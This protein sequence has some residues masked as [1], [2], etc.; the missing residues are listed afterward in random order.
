MTQPVVHVALCTTGTNSTDYRDFVAHEAGWR[1]ARS[2]RVESFIFW[3]KNGGE[4]AENTV[5]IKKRGCKTQ[6]RLGPRH[7]RSDVCFEFDVRVCKGCKHW[8]ACS[9][10]VQQ[11]CLTFVKQASFKAH[12]TGQQA[13]LTFVKHCKARLLSTRQGPTLAEIHHSHA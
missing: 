3:V 12:I 10:L 13:C 6:F 2:S 5:F 1:G 7:L 4:K 9:T 11:A 8:Q